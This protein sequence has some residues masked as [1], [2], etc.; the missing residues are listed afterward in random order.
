MI[1]NKVAKPTMTLIVSKPILT[2]S[3]VFSSNLNFT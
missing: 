2:S 3:K 1:K